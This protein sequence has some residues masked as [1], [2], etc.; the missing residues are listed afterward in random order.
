MIIVNGASTG[1]GIT[2][3]NAFGPLTPTQDYS[4]GGY[5]IIGKYAPS[6]LAVGGSGIRLVLNGPVTPGNT[7]SLAGAYISLAANT[8]GSDVYDAD[9]TPT[10][11][12][13]NSLA[14]LSMVRGG[15]YYS[16][17][18]SFTIDRTR[19]IL[20]AF[21][22]AS[23]TQWVPF[24]SGLPTAQYSYYSKAAVQEA[25]D[26]NRAT[27]YGGGGGFSPILRALQCYS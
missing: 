4:R 15:V 10:A 17:N 26:T 1:G 2:V 14:T 6:V 23:G 19:A 27:G 25:D 24:S 20:I 21:N 3:R 11:V 12:T 5:T 9:T 22:I 8:A 16:D 13:F 18:I 7:C